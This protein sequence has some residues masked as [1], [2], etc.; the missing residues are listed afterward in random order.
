MIAMDW[1][2]PSSGLSDRVRQGLAARTPEERLALLVPLAQYRLTYLE[3]V[4]LDR[5]LQTVASVGDSAQSRVRLAILASA[6]VDHLAPAVRVAGLRRGLWIDTYIAPYGQYRQELLGASTG[7]QRF[8][9]HFVLFAIGVGETIAGIPIDATATDVH[10]RV[11]ATIEEL[12]QLWELA[13]RNLGAAVMQQTF[14]NHEDSLFGS[15]DRLTPGSPTTVIRRLNERLAEAAADKSVML[16]DVAGASERDGLDAWFDRSRYFEAKMEIA[17]QAAASYGELVT[18]SIAAQRG[19]SRKCLVLDLDN[20]LWGG[21]VGD[22]GIEGIVLGQGNAAGEAHLALQRYAQRLRERGVILAVCSRNDPVI[23][24]TAVR[25]HPEMLLRR[26]EFAAFVANWDDKSSN[27]RLIAQQLNIGL[28]S[29]VFVD[30]N[31]AE[32]ARIRE[33][34]PMVGVPELPANVADYVT[35]L[36][37]AGY[38]EAVA[39]TPEDRTRGE[40]YA[41]SASRDVLLKS[42]QSLDDFLAGLGM[43]VAFGAFRRVDLA[44]VTQLINKT[45]QFNLTTLRYSADDVERF[46]SAQRCLTLQFRLLDRFGDNGL[47]SV[48]ILR[49]D[50]RRADTLLVDT[51]VMSCRVFGRQLEHEAMNIAIEVARANG[52]EFLQGDYVP[53]PKNAVVQDLYG[54]LGFAPVHDAVTATGVTRWSLRL[55]DYAPHSTHIVRKAELDE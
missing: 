16:V 18:R 12:S 19:L 34:L 42:S 50:E 51:W 15:Y 2:P 39:F 47:V 20:T 17:P 11:S 29:L 28:D 5:A 54:R 3:T 55:S 48:M 49:R 4:Q 7:I 25:E 14:L 23:A 13:R 22:D 31:P 43:T 1:L 33:S 9:P 8:D 36:A 46:F 38:F 10:A 27:L 32:R 21:V 52:A 35:C 53:T 44:R 6:T 45:N 40:Q 37:N 30:D 26:T 41:A 24:E